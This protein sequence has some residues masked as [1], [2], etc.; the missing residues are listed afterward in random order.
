MEERI[1][2]KMR[3]TENVPTDINEPEDTLAYSFSD[4]N[5]AMEERIVKKMRLTENVP[6]D[7]NEPEDTLGIHE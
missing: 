7:I 2:K 6:T 3:L 5:T 4:L 1:V